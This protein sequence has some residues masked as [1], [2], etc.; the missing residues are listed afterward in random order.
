MCTY[1]HTQTDTQADTNAKVS[2]F[3]QRGLTFSVTH[4]LR[5]AESLSRVRLL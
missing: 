5:C 2:K 1:V 3:L 4:V